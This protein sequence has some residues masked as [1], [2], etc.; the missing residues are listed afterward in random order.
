MRL[1]LRVLRV[2]RLLGALGG[3]VDVVVLVPGSGGAGEN[4]IPDDGFGVGLARFGGGVDGFD[5]EE[6]LLGVPVEEGGQICA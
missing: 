5:V 4:G 3:R 2:L 6:D 1:C